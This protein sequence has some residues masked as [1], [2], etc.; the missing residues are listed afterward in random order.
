MPHADRNYWEAFYER[1]G[2]TTEPSPFARSC[3]ERYVRPG[4]RLVE[5]GCGNGRDAVALAMAGAAVTAIDQCAKTIA[6]LEGANRPLKG[7]RFVADDFVRYAY[8]PPLDVFY[9][10]F[11]LHAVG[12]KDEKLLLEAVTGVLSPGGYLLLEFRGRKNELNGV[13]R[14]VEGEEFM[15]EHEGHRRRF[16][17]SEALAGRLADAGMDILAC[18]EKPGF[19]PFQGKDEVFARI[20]A[21][22]RG[23]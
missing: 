3:I 9:S 4:H 14:P 2:L 6:K 7:L 22:S 18:E 21:K 8:A 17:D 12:A 20:I 16:I 13:G 1:S 23:A 5:A 19:S 10:R 11:T 15:F